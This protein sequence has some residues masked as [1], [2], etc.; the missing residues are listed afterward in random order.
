MLGSCRQAHFALAMGKD[1]AAAARGGG[2]I[3]RPVSDH[4]DTFNC[5]D[6]ESLS[7]E[8]SVA[9]RATEYYS[10]TES[11]R[12]AS[13]E[14]PFKTLR[15][16]IFLRDELE[17]ARHARRERVAS[18]FKDHG[19]HLH[20]ERCGV[21]GKIVQ[22]S[23]GKGKSRYRCR[24]IVSGKTQCGK[25]HGIN[26]LE[27]W[28]NHV[29]KAETEEDYALATGAKGAKEM[30]EYLAV[31]STYSQEHAL[32]PSLVDI[33]AANNRGT[34]DPDQDEH[35][36]DE[37]FTDYTSKAFIEKTHDFVFQRLLE[38]PHIELSAKKLSIREEL[39]ILEVKEGSVKFTL[40]EDQFDPWKRA[41]ETELGIELR[42]AKIRKLKRTGNKEVNE[43]YLCNY[44][45]K[46]RVPKTDCSAQQPEAR[47][48]KRKRQSF[49]CGCKGRITKSRKNVVID[50]NQSITTFDILYSIGHNH[51]VFDKNTAGSRRISQEAKAWI[52]REL[53][54]GVSP[55]EVMRT[56]TEALRE[57]RLRDTAAGKRP[58]RDHY[59]SYMDVYNVYY[60]VFRKT[61]EESKGDAE[62][63]AADG[64]D[65]GSEDEEEDV[66]VKEEE[67]DSADDSGVSCTMR[68][69]EESEPSQ[70]ERL[71]LLK[72][73]RGEMKCRRAKR[74]KTER[75]DEEST[76]QLKSEFG[77][78][79]DKE[80]MN[81]SRV[82]LTE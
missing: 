52:E 62:V 44:H 46:R 2:L 61:D 30:Q 72:K 19:S 79:L 64:S 4:H 36:C 66:F 16:G 37:Q 55:K 81:D 1:P 33:E 39:K 11:N 29:S 21:Q 28:L 77:E 8:G 69:D 42:L 60:R 14:S 22:E 23:K 54:R 31:Q 47:K 74:M 78:R 12:S 50:G 51:P 65:D 76:K 18:L 75:S 53:L 58:H 9:D 59:I 35:M 67:D 73:L 17:H 80:S 27:T 34:E 6:N 71:L 20:C 63:P 45:G 68:S 10:S 82:L 70:M 3:S 25:T 43:T 40:L 13:E 57:I 24:G 15:T 56:S 48:M 41:H 49:K 7:T 32:E 5:C 26:S 38:C